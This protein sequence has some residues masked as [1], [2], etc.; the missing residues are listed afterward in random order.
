[1]TLALAG[2]PTVLL[3]LFVPE[4]HLV[5]CTPLGQDLRGGAEMILSREAG[6]RFLGYLRT[7]RDQLVGVGGGRHNNRP[8][9]IDL[10][11]F[12]T[13][14]AMH[15]VR[16]GVQGV[17]LLETGRISLPVSEPWLGWLRDL[18]RG[19]H[20]KEE[21]LDAAADLEA[22]IEGLMAT[23]ALPPHPDRERADRWLVGAYRAVWAD[24][25]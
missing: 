9:L 4:V 11:G 1:M 24:G 2:N 7:Q 5:A 3:P 10:Y 21:A 25:G 16:L 18:R 8:E 13:K 22:R 6:E 19:R 12:D 20:S 17:E 15:M 23:S 14:Y